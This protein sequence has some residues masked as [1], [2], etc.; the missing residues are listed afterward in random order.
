[1]QPPP[2]P[3]Q[4]PVYNQNPYTPQPPYIPPVY[5]PVPRAPRGTVS[6]EVISEAWSYLSPNLGPWVL[7][8][9]AYFGIPYAISM[10]RGIFQML[11]QNGGSSLWLILAFLIQVVSWVVTQLLLGGM[12]KMAIGTVR[13]RVANINEMWTVTGEG[14]NLV[15]SAIL[16][17]LI[18]SL[19]CLPGILVLGASVFVPLYKAGIFSPAVLASGRA[20]A[21]PPALIG[22]MFGGIGLGA[23]LI[24]L[25]ATP[26]T[27]LFLLTTTLIVERK[28]GPWEAIS[29][30]IGA[31]KKHF[32]PTV[33]L[34]FVLG[35]VNSAGFMMCCVGILFSFPLVQIATALVYRDLFGI[36]EAAPQS[37]IYA[38]PPPIANPNF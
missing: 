7:A 13:N 33:L 38:P 32:W 28:L 26:L 9:V 3:N 1:M 16:R 35:L 11:G 31:L 24:F 15:L 6:L 5:G 25:A 22:T 4:Q 8:S 19:A 29:Q 34:S 10:V 20:P 2:D 23:L 36:D 12:M 14:L 21:V 37:T 30:S 27:A 17:G 18:Y